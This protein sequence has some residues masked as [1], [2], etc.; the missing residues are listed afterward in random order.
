[1][2]CGQA[3]QDKF[4]LNVLKE[5]RNGYYVEI[6][7]NHPF[8]INNT[9]L[10]ETSYNW[11]GIM[12]EYESRFLPLYINYR[13]NSHYIIKDATLVDYKQAFTEYNVPP[14]IDYLQI[15]LEASNG[16]TLKTLELL[17]TQVMDT[18]KFATVT[19]EHDVYQTPVGSTR[20]LSREIFKRH[21][22]FCVFE[23]IHNIEPQYVYEDW[24]VHP[25]L[26]DMEYVNNLKSSNAQY[27][28]ENPITGK[29]INWQDIHY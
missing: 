17:D 21:G 18:Y 9:Y 16:S 26:V 2:Y 8:T 19:F 28:V 22:Y 10:L 12:V 11:K 23:D 1:M 24:Y 27:Y 25:D 6:G 14:S 29:S 15:D 13:P 20:T 7:S 3:Q 4:I 5:K